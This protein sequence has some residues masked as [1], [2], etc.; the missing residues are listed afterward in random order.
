MRVHAWA[1][2]ELRKRAAGSWAMKRTQVVFPW[3]FAISTNVQ[4]RPDVVD[5]RD[6]VSAHVVLAYGRDGR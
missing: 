6:W 2:Q 1:G 4:Q 3:V 5:D